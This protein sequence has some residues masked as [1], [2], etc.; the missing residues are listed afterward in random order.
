MEDMGVFYDFCI[1]A[2]ESEGGAV[3]PPASGS[4]N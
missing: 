3:I 2:L 1:E 4:A